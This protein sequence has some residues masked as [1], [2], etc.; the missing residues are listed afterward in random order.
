MST[1]RSSLSATTTVA[2]VLALSLT[3]CSGKAQNEDGAEKEGGV[4]TGVG[5][6][7]ETITLG[8]LTD[9][10]GAY[11]TLGT[12]ITQSQ[13][14]YLDEVNAAGG[15]CGRE[16]RLEVR[17]HGY[18]AEAAL[19]AYTELEPSVLAFPQFIGSPFVTAVKER[20]DEQDQ[21]MVF[22]QAWSDSLLGSRYIHMIG[23]TYDYETLNAIDFLVE[24][25]GLAKG[26]SIGHIYFEGD[27]GE[28]AVEGSRYAA[29]ELGLTVVEQQIKPTD[30]DMTAQVGALARADVSAILISAGPRQGASVA[31]VAAATGLEVP[32][33]GNN[34]AFAPQ[35]LETDAGPALMNDFYIVSPAYPIGSPEET[36]T[37]LAQAY[38]KEF[39]DAV[40]DNGVTA[41]YNAVSL[42][43]L[44]LEAA[45][46]AGDLTREGVAQGMLSLDS[47]DNGFGIEHDFSRP[48][49]PSS[50]ESFL[51]KPDDTVPGGQVAH[52]GPWASGLAEA[53]SQR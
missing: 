27:Y 37:A 38:Q 1:R 26:D 12:S 22:P 42:F 7:D 14:L 31:G 30:E 39:P 6:T 3:A 13:Q 16:L 23:A 28:T 35:L 40:L 52:Q 41:G 2:A 15:I 9:M 21:V 4:A 49:V 8:A 19:S 50:L 45:C 20:I 29:N 17:D 11:A 25:K 47:V 53:F 51:L 44:A 43:G 24:E 36:P 34:S 48:E 10:T 33:V 18:D 5:V 46:E 32:I